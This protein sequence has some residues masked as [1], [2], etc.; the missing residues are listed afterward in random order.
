MA[1]SVSSRTAPGPRGHILLGSLPDFQR[2]NIRA[3]MDAWRRYGDVVRF[4]GRGAM[5]LVVHPDHVKHVLQDRHPDYPRPWWVDDKLKG[6]VGE[7]LVASEG[8][9]WR[10]QRRL[11]QPVFHRQRIG[12]FGT[13]MTDTTGEMLERWE[14][15]AARGQA[16]NMRVAMQNLSLAILARSLFGADWGP[17]AAAVG[18]AVT[19]A[20]E[21]TNRR[22]LSPIDPPEWVPL[23]HIRRWLKARRT[24]DSL[25]YRLIAERRRAPA[26]GADLVSMLIQARDE[27]TGEGMTDEQLRDEIMG[28]L[29]AGHETVSS[30]LTWTWYLLSLHP[31][32]AGRLRSE[33]VEV[34]GGRTPTV[35]DAAHLRYTTMVLQEAMRLY[36]PIWVM[37]RSPQTDDTIGGYHIPARSTVILCPYVTHR[38]PAF[39]ENPEGFDPE[40]FTPER[41]ADRPRYAYFPFGGGPRLCI[42]ESFG[43]LEMQLVIAMMAQRYRPDLAPGYPVVPQP[44][45][46]LRARYGMGMTLQPLN[47]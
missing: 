17:E 41:S 10:R 23:P 46:S 29:I 4:R 8:E 47:N 11:A 19:I 42:G 35:A 24:L 37:L 20:L 34:L 15:Y 9:H 38:H 44:A 39:W 14:A 2:D 36:P 18:P 13:V 5:F 25:V 1:A 7:G 16:I 12:A 27:E 21:H 30:A 33:L 32:V 22:L 31:D 26:D 43:M 28:F 6:V 40:R 45:I 3:F